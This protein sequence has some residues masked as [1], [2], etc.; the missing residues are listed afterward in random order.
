MLIATPTLTFFGDSFG[1]YNGLRATDS[2]QRGD[3]DVDKLNKTTYTEGVE[4]T[5][6]EEAIK[7]FILARLGFPT[8]RVELTSYQLKTCID[9]AVSKLSYHAPLF[10][11]QYC[12]FDASAGISTY[13]LPSFIM[14]NLTSVTYK[15]GMMLA[16]G[17]AGTFESDAMLLYLTNNFQNL[18]YTM[19]DWYVM[20][21]H[22]EMMRKIYGRDGGW[23]V[24]DGQYLLLTPTPSMTPETVI[25][26]YRALNS[27]TLMPAY[28]NWIQKYALAIS[29]G[30]LGE[31]R[32]KFGQ[33]PGPQGG[34]SLNGKDLLMASEKEKEKLEV[35]LLSEIEEPPTFSVY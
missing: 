21:Q 6:F 8:V 16:A 3:I 20:Q 4:F 23:T 17:N 11:T 32:S 35:A 33:V 26:E 9:E 30:V 29:K 15:K 13:K 12:S 18:S 10:A 25:A 24:L 28:R 5:T 34:I 14:N 31:V 19:G 7:D 27:D 2:E 22:F 1:K